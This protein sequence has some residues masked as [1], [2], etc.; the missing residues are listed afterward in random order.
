MEALEAVSV[1]SLL[2][3]LVHGF[4]DDLSTLSVVAFSVAIASA[5]LAEDHIVWAEKLSDGGRS[6]TIDDAWFEVD[7]DCS[8]H[9]SAS[10]CFVVVHIDPFKLQI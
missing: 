7:E 4:I 9:I 8:G 3:Y 1:L 5:V 2:P 6:H 10:I